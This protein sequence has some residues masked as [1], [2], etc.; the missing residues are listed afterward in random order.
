MAV[1]LTYAA[2]VVAVWWHPRRSFEVIWLVFMLLG[3]LPQLSSVISEGC[4]FCR[5]ESLWAFYAGVVLSLIGW[6]R[7]TDEPI[8][9]GLRVSK[10]LGWAMGMAHF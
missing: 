2:F 6:A 1:V 9:M 3:F 4:M 5:R 10:C 7:P 8:C